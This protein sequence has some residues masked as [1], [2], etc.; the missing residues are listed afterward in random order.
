MDLKIHSTLS[1]AACGLLTFALG[2]GGSTIGTTLPSVTITSPL[3][4]ATVTPDADKSVLVAFT[5][6]NFTLKGPGMCGSV[7][8][9]CGHVHLLIDGS[10]C[11]PAGKP[12]NN[13]G[14][15]SPIKAEFGSCP[16]VA[17]SHTI[18]LELHR[19][20]HS[21]ISTPVSGAVTVTVAGAATGP[22]ITIV[23]PQNNATIT[24]GSDAAMSVPV[25]F[26]TANFTLMGPGMCPSVSDSCGHVHLTVDGTACN[27]MGK[28]YNNAGAASPI[29]ANLATCAMAN[30]SHTIKVELHRNDHSLVATGNPTSSVVVMAG[31]AGPSI[32]ITSPQNGAAVEAGTDMDKSVPV[33]FTVQGFTLMAPG[34]C[35]SVSDTCGHVHLFV[36]GAACTPV[37]KPYNNGG[38]ASPLNAKLASCATPIGAHTISLELHRNDHTPVMTGSP[39]ASVMVTVGTGG[40]PSITITSPQNGAMVQAGTDM[41]KIVPVSFT[42]QGFTLM[43][44]GTCPTIDDTCGHVHLLVDGAACTP[45]GQ[46]YNNGGAASPINAKMASCPTPTGAHTISLEL[47]R[48]DHTPVMTGSPT[49]IA[50]V[51]V[52]G[53]VI[54]GSPSITITS[55]QNQAVVTLGTDAMRSVPVAFTVNNFTLMAA[56]TCAGAP[57]CGHVHLNV[58]ATACNVATAPYNNHAISSPVNAQFGLCMNPA[59]VHQINVSLHND[60]HSLLM[61]NGMPA[62]NEV[63]ITTM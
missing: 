38:A 56:G 5:V 14:A 2:C 39:T 12:Y 8:D 36:D 31:A 3:T 60:D 34:T 44:P 37:G 24:P 46:P 62:D 41:D 47:H 7:S 4:G 29:N 35:P 6:N 26:S 51:T 18:T 23:S 43:A 55:P 58:D 19:D 53:G 48:S 33:S 15:A 40:T 30:G 63:A 42:V 17:G 50:M 21:T 22:I 20:D 27:A 16:T 11:T 28:P 9:A 32:T 52:M 45:A 57:N 54:G 10:A 59:G 13:G 1:L 25:S 49:A 61:V